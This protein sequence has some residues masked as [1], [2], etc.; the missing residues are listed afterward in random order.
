MRDIVKLVD[1]LA[2]TTPYDRVIPESE[3]GVYDPNDM[4]YLSGDN[5]RY[6]HDLNKYVRD[7]NYSREAEEAEY[8]KKLREQ[9]ALEA[10]LM[11]EQSPEFIGPRRE[12]Y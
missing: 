4:F 3:L 12:K 1:T 6:D 8:Y 9:Q 7:E 10:L 5:I 2:R 11:L